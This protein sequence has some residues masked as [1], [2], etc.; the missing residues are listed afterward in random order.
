M[1]TE[2]VIKRDALI[3]A[4][5]KYANKLC[6]VKCK[7]RESPEAWAAKW[8]FAYHQK[9]NELARPLL[10]VIPFEYVC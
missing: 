5:M 4:A 6:G 3:P 10:A 9:M 8:N 1:N 2:Y 7:N